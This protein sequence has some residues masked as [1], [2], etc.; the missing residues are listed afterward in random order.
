[1]QDQEAD[2]EFAQQSCA[3]SWKNPN[4]EEQQRHLSSYLD[5]D[6]KHL[7]DQYSFRNGHCPVMLSETKFG[8]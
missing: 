8:A 7:E 3:R 1:M 6:I 4:V 5:K 2:P